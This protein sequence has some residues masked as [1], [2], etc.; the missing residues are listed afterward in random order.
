MGNSCKSK[1]YE[2]DE[3]QRDDNEKVLLIHD[4][5][6]IL[7]TSYCY[8]DID[9]CH[10][11]GTCSDDNRI[12]ILKKDD[13]N[14]YTVCH[15]LLGHEKA[16]NK[17]AMNKN[18]LWSASRDLSL[19][20]WNINNDKCLQ[21]ISK[22]HELNVSAVVTSLDNSTIYSGSRDYSV[23]VWDSEKG[24]CKE[25]YKVPRNIVTS[26]EIGREHLLYQGSEDLCVRVWDTR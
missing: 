15:Y 4:G 7:S 8:N 18:T 25:Q 16:V 19:K 26:L 9:Q 12:G 5:S 17:I 20:Q 13:T 23:K 14:R 21:T 11:I 1:S 2:Y 10:Y 24:V 22:A 3:Q 6:S